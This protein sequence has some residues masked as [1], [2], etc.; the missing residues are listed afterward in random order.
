MNQYWLPL[1][2]ILAVVTAGCQKSN[3]ETETKTLLAMQSIYAN[4]CNANSRPP[5]DSRD[6]LA[7]AEGSIMSPQRGRKL[8]RPALESGDYVVIWDADYWGDL[9][10]SE[11]RILAYQAKTPDSGGLVAFTLTR[12]G[13]FVHYLTAEEF[14]KT[15]KVATY[16]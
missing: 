15:P 16:Q 6:F 7:F 14:E 8:C 12:D 4:F 2:L 13:S 9:D 10:K 11:P 3:L 1:I 5:K